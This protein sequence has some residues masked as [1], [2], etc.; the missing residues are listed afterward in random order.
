[1]INSGRRKLAEE[2][3]RKAKDDYKSA[4]VVLEEGGYYG[5]TCFL[6]QQ[7]AEKYLKGF[8]V[9]R[10]K[11]FQKIHDLIKLLNECKEIDKSFNELEDEC[12]LLNEYYIETRYPVDAPIDYSKTEAK[13]AL[14]ASEKIMNF[15]S[16]R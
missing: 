12:I 13:F 2:W 3:F 5:T 8:L 15:I 7:I 14:T 10:G 9:S 16:I 1:M 4:E 6:S 11:R